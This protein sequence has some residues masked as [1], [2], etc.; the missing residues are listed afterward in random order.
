[1]ARL[2]ETTGFAALLVALLVPG[3]VAAQ[4]DETAYARWGGLS[5]LGAGPNYSDIGAGVF[6]VRAT[7]EDSDG[8]AAWR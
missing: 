5:V 8:S 6:D 7:F 1:M 3:A 4:D 2:L